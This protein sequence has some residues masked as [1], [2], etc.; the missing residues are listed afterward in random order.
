MLSALAAPVSGTDAPHVE[1]VASHG[2]PVLLL[3][4]PLVSAPAA[5]IPPPPQGGLAADVS[6]AVLMAGSS[7]SGRA[8]PRLCGIAQQLVSTQRS[9]AVQHRLT[10]TDLDAG[11]SAEPTK[12][13]AGADAKLTATGLATR[14]GLSS[15]TSVLQART[16]TVTDDSLADDSLAS[17]L[18]ATT[19]AS[20]EPDVSHE[21]ATIRRAT[22]DVLQLQANHSGLLSRQSVSESLYPTYFTATRDG[23]RLANLAQPL[24][25]S[26]STGCEQFLL[27]PVNSGP[28][29]EQVGQ[30]KGVVAAD[31]IVAN[32]FNSQAIIQQM[33]EISQQSVV[34]DANS[35]E[36]LVE[37]ADKLHHG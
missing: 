37:T 16:A 33:M 18:I 15:S 21:D 9:G 28:V 23:A 32:V 25:G 2:L 10:I 34:V 29:M 26:L 5:S 4:E 31:A 14:T 27:I 6:G 12:P 3:N 11:T 36:T 30:T 7:E 22:T 13:A 20:A 8:R 17:A 19:Q 24:S 1:D 35:S